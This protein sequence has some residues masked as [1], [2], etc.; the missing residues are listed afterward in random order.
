MSEFM[1]AFSVR[2]ARNLSECHPDLQRL[3]NDVIEHFDCSVLCGHRN[4]R[5]QEIA[6]VSGNSNAHFGES[7]HNS[8][9]AMAVDVV[10]YPIDW[11]D[12]CRFALF[13]GFV[14]GRAVALDINIRWGADWDSDK[15]MVDETF[16]DMPHFELM[17][18]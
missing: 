8:V 15:Q 10:P 12:D 11:D 3:F 14:M 5:D 13:A 18:Y 2:S 17:D 6:Y 9:P 16:V 7:K 4:E 1:S